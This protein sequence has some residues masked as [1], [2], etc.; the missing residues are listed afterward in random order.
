MLLSKEDNTSPQTYEEM[1]DIDLSTNTETEVFDDI[2]ST[3]SISTLTDQIFS[4][5]HDMTTHPSSTNNVETNLPLEQAKEDNGLEK[6]NI[7]SEIVGTYT[8]YTVT[9]TIGSSDIESTELSDD[10]LFY[11]LNLGNKTQSNSKNHSILSQEAMD[12]LNK[13]ANV[14]T[15]EPKTSLE[16]AEDITTENSFELNITK[17]IVTEEDKLSTKAISSYNN[18]NHAGIPILTKIYNKAPQKFDDKVPTLKSSPEEDYADLSNET[19]N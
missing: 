2:H 15:N 17:P 4:T 8:N 3:N 6:I 10:E 9:K 1:P 13:L 7:I 14:R 16:I 19:G 12:A 5:L 11:L 18:N